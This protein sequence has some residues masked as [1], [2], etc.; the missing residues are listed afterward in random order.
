MTYQHQVP[1][2]AQLVAII[3]A[4]FA[5]ASTVTLWRKLT[6]ALNADA[7]LDGI[8]GL[9]L[10]AR[11][12]FVVCNVVAAFLLWRGR[13]GGVVATVMA[14]AISLSANTIEHLY[15]SSDTALLVYL[16]PAFALYATLAFVAWLSIKGTDAGKPIDWSEQK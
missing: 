7:D 8:D 12:C 14:G 3:L 9:M 16:L 11:G 1:F 10:A 4:F 15:R 5:I 2:R 13:L 6:I